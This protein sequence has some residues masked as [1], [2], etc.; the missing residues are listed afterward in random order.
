[1][2]KRICFHLYDE[3]DSGY[4][5]SFPIEHELSA[6]ETW[7]DCADEITYGAYRYNEDEQLEFVAE[8][9]T[10]EELDVF[11]EENES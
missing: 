9:Y 3:L 4:V 7:E 11:I 5:E 2:H 6:R 1:M 10:S 8:F